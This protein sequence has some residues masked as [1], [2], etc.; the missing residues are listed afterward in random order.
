MLWQRQKKLKEKKLFL[1][2]QNAKTEIITQQK[3]RQTIQT[4]WNLKNIAQLA[5]KPQLIKRQN[6]G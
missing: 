6:K 5:E 1:N 2:A 4:G 3:I